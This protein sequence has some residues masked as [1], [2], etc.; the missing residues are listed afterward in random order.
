M[1]ISYVITP[2]DASIITSPYADETEK[3]LPSITFF[4]DA[5]DLLPVVEPIV[6]V[7]FTFANFKF[8]ELGEFFL[9]AGIEKDKLSSTEIQYSGKFTIM[10]PLFGQFVDESNIFLAYDNT[11]FSGAT[12]FE[13]VLVD[14]TISDSAGTTP[15]NESWQWT[16]PFVVTNTEDVLEYNVNTPR[17]F[18]DIFQFEDLQPTIDDNWNFEFFSPIYDHS[19]TLIGDIDLDP[20]F[21]SL[22]SFLFEDAIGPYSN[23]G[24]FFGTLGPNND[25]FYEFRNDTVFYWTKEVEQ[26]LDSSFEKESLVARINARP[27]GVHIENI[28]SANNK[29]FIYYKESRNLVDYFEFD[30]N[31]LILKQTITLPTGFVRIENI[32]DGNNSKIFDP[33]VFTFD[34]Y[35]FIFA[36]INESDT[37]EAYKFDGAVY[38]HESTINLEFFPYRAVYWMSDRF[39]MYMTH[40]VDTEDDLD[41]KFLHKPNLKIYRRTGTTWEILNEIDFFSPETIQNFRQNGITP[42]DRIVTPGRGITEATINTALQEFDFGFII[43]IPLEFEDLGQIVDFITESINAGLI[44][45]PIDAVDVMSGI[46]SI[47]DFFI[48]WFDNVQGDLYRLGGASGTGTNGFEKIKTI[49]KSYPGHNYNNTVMA[50]D[51]IF[52]LFPSD[53]ASGPSEFGYRLGKVSPVFNI[54]ST[55]LMRDRQYW[56][57]TGENQGWVSHYT[58]Y[59]SDNSIF[60]FKRINDVFWGSIK[61]GFVNDLSFNDINELLINLIYTQPVDFDREFPIYWSL[62]NARDNSIFTGDTFNLREIIDL[63]FITPAGIIATISEFDNISE[64]VIAIDP[65]DVFAVITY[66]LFSGALPTGAVLNPATGEITGFNVLVTF[67]TPFT[68]EIEAT[69]GVKTTVR[70]FTI[71]IEN[72]NIPPIWSTPVGSLGVF[73]DQNGGGAP[74]SIF[75]LA[76]DADGP[77]PLSYGLQSGTLPGGLLLD[78]VTGEISGVLDDVASV[79]LSVF[80]IRASD[81]ED[82]TDR[83]FSI[84]VTDNN[85]PPLWST[86]S[87]LLATFLSTDPINFL[88]VASDGDGP[89]PVSYALTAGAL[90]TGATLNTSTGYQK[91]INR[92]S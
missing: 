3:L 85:E 2:K 36:G 72:D 61:R 31:D 13:N 68:F 58:T 20:G 62:S 84:V 55:I 48:I 34:E 76:T 27:R 5:G 67:D 82:F 18:T 40:D 37:I 53:L 60:K 88:L 83:T 50:F 65:T 9:P 66:S 43:E 87:G 52:T 71:V 19:Q 57:Q 92:I 7:V 44:V 75:V 8:A 69:N 16:P 25:F 30:G 79:T 26:L 89:S 46:F 41:D 1:T 63:S 22:N 15:V 81:T 54:L 47:D 24:K 51:S 39:F 59:G 33:S 77:G 6:T 32:L 11:T 56:F 21:V 4:A 10:A 73:S 14:V 78:T 70:E 45:D 90:P 80:T 28:Y 38:L 74:I 42:F 23:L 35:L 49:N 12:F 17:T 91:K 86:A 64:Q 29:M